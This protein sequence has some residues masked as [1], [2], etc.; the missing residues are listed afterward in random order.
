MLYETPFLTVYIISLTAITGLVAGSFI[1]CAAMRAVRREPI[2][3]GR[4][5]CPACGHTLAAR[6]LVPLFSWL[7]LKGKC[8]YCGAP[9]SRRYPASELLTAAVFVSALLKWDVSLRAAEMLVLGAILLYLSLVDAEASLI[10]N[11]AIGAGI[12][13]RAVFVCSPAISGGRR[14]SP[15]SAASVCLCRCCSSSLGWRSF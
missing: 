11:R 9:V 3:H 8:R 1:N 14:L 15:S 4:S 5:H 7:F 2:A 6:D 12:A 13:A 10:P